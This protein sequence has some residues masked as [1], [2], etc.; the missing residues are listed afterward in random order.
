MKK[1]RYN[2]YSHVHRYVRYELF[3]F[4]KRI[5]KIDFR[6]KQQTIDA[7]CQL[8]N[9][10]MLINGHAAHEDNT[11]HQLFRDAHSDVYNNVEAEHQQH[12]VEFDKI[13][14][15]LSDI[16]NSNIHSDC[17]LKG[18]EF[19]LLVNKFVADSLN[20]LEHEE[21]ILMSELQN[22]YSDDEIRALTFKTYD[23]MKPDQM[24]HMIQTIFPHVNSYE[25]EVFIRDIYDSHPDKLSVIWPNVW[26]LLGDDEREYFQKNLGLNK[27]NETHSPLQRLHYKWQRPM[28]GS[29]LAE[30]FHLDESDDHLAKKRV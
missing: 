27:P 12:A 5:G 24:L 9:F 18:Y 16:L 29:T 17:H 1:L 21:K 7:K 11:V 4:S 25:R 30:T 15:L 3:E 6:D 13:E 26:D 19:Y 20:H 8:D 23:H 10:K 28:D 14:G 22:L 2:F